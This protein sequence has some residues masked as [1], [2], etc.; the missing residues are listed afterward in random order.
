ME[1]YDL[2][3]FDEFDEIIV[4]YP[5]EFKAD[6][7][8][9]F[10]GIWNLNQYKVIGLSA[11]ASS[12]IVNILEDVVTDGKEVTILEFK[13]EYEFVSLNSPM[14]GSVITLEENASIIDE[15]MKYCDKNYCKKPLI[16]FLDEV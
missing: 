5:Y 3:I 13:S 6:S 9:I 7:N 1:K 10:N 16:C 11:T 14:N 15:I 12:E 2:V 4:Q 8:S